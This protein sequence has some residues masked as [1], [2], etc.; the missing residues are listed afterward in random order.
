[1]HKLSASTEG[2]RKPSRFSLQKH[3]RPRKERERGGGGGIKIAT[4]RRSFRLERI[5]SPLRFAGNALHARSIKVF[6]V[7]ST[8]NSSPPSFRRRRKRG[9][10]PLDFRTATNTGF[11]SSRAVVQFPVHRPSCP[12]HG[13]VSPHGLF[14]NSGPRRFKRHKERSIALNLTRRS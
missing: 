4:S 10:P 7:H 12:A 2:N 6:F 11:S 13:A 9:G 14:G 5:P 3:F 1:M 8:P